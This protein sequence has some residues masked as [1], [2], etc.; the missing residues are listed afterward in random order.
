MVDLP[1]HNEI[2]PGDFLFFRTD[3]SRFVGTERYYEH[4]E[5]SLEVAEWLASSEINMVGIDA[6]GLGRDRNHGLFDRM[7]IKRDIFII[8]NL[9]N[10]SAIPGGEFRA[11]C[12]PLKLTGVDAVPARVVVEI[13]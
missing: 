11:Y 4:P 1:E 12:F 5:F 2:L 9:T 10:L 3:W 8:E 7:L 13:P 6:L